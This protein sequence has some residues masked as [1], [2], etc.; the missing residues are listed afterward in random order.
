V[1]IWR[2]NQRVAQSELKVKFVEE[3]PRQESQQPPDVRI[4][5][6]AIP[7]AEQGGPNTRAQIGGT[8]R[9]KVAL[10]DL[11]VIYVRAFG[12][13]HVQPIPRTMHPIH[14]GNKWGSWTHTGTKYAALL[15]RPDYEP[16]KTLDMLR[17]RT[18]SFSP[19]PSWTAS[20]QASALMRRRSPISIAC[21]GSLRIPTRR[22]RPRH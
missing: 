17:K 7:P 22:P 18:P 9:G 2:E 21:A 1:E 4:E 5:I 10:D 6:T 19:R 16:I 12:A 20:P 14:E 8:V 15:V 13:W 3:R 11:V